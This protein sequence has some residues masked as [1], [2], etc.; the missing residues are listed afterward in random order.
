MSR[1]NRHHRSWDE[2]SSAVEFAILLPVLVMLMLGFI[3]FGRALW[4]RTTVQY[5]IDEAARYAMIYT[6]ASATQIRDRAFAS[7][8]GLPAADLT[9]TVDLSEAGYVSI[10]GQYNFSPIAGSSFIHAIPL[11]T[12]TRMPRG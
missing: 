4:A 1:K 9:F 11:Q 5:A 8:T 7:A 3:E 6:T 12:T 2:G 10:I